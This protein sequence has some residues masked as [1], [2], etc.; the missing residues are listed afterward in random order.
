YAKRALP[1]RFVDLHRENLHCNLERMIDRDS[2]SDCLMMLQDHYT[3]L[4]V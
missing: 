4:V 1:F 3:E 2:Y